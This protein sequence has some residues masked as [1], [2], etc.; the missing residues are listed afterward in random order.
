MRQFV[1]LLVLVLISGQSFGQ[2][3]PKKF[4]RDFYF[5]SGS[6]ELDSAEQKKAKVFA[7]ILNKFELTKIELIG[8]TDSDG[9]EASNL[10]LAKKRINHLKSYYPEILPDSLFLIVPQGEKDPVYDNSDASKYK[11]R[12]VRIKAYYKG[13]KV[14]VAK[15]KS[16]PKKIE[17]KTEDFTAGKTIELPAVQ[18]YGGTAQFLPGATKILDQVIPVLKKNPN[19][20]IEIAGHICCGNQMELSIERAYVVYYYFIDR[21][22]PRKMLTYKGYNN[23]QPKYGNI[24]DY[25]NRRV[26]LIVLD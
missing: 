15:K 25:R 8:Y 13:K 9:S 2:K 4:T 16:K 7:K 5:E 17:L 18:F 21:G 14:T 3:K 26:E 24:M 12:R 10:E 23:T 11:N 22:V 6:F 20:N 19:L 1:I